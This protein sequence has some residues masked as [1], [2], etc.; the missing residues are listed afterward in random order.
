MCQAVLLT[1]ENLRVEA[2]GHTLI[3]L[4]FLQVRRSEVLALL[5]PNG[6]GKSTLLQ[7]LACLRTPVSG[8]LQFDGHSIDLRSPPLAL[9]RRLA[10]V[11]QEPL[12]FDTTVEE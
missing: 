7:T 1:V 5:G 9:R 3:A 8:S 12:L 10:V 6:A 11:F 4:P 2:S